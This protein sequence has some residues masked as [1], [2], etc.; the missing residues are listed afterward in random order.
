MI[1]IK[2][3]KK[4]FVLNINDLLLADTSQ[5][6]LLLLLLLFVDIIV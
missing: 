6:I 2:H 4:I 1:S 3:I 5:N